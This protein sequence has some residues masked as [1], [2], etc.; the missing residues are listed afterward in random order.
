MTKSGD[1]SLIPAGYVRYADYLNY[2]GSGYS[3]I[4]YLGDTYWHTHYYYPFTSQNM[5]ARFWTSSS[6]KF[7]GMSYNETGIYYGS[8]EDSRSAFSMRCVKDYN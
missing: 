1:F 8:G 7:R 2:Y 4:C 3:Y 6:G 5:V